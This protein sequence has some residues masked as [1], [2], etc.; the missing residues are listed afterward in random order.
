MTGSSASKQLTV[1]HQK[2]LEKREADKWK[3]EN[4]PDSCVDI[5]QMDD[6]HNSDNSAELNDDDEE[7]E[8]DG[9]RA[10]EM[11]NGEKS[12]EEGDVFAGGMSCGGRDWSKKGRQSSTESRKSQGRSEG[13]EEAE[14]LF[15]L[16]AK[17]D[18]KGV[19][20]LLLSSKKI[21]LSSRNAVSTRT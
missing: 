14:R 6:I 9:E 4:R 3:K 12:P 17:K 13:D 16:I 8:L 11:E 2:G 18:Q 21:H 19:E 20:D 15:Q 1:N 5:F 10:E 7:E